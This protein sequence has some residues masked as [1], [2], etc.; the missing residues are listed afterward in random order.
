MCLNRPWQAANQSSSLPLI[1][2][3][4]QAVSLAAGPLSA[5]GARTLSE[6]PRVDFLAQIELTMDCQKAGVLSMEITPAALPKRIVRVL[7]RGCGLLWGDPRLPGGVFVASHGRTT[8][9]TDAD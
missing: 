5:A 9:R 1:L 4:A 3:V 2:S 8:A 7:V 6:R